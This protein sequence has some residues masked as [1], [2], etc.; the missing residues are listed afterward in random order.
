M[1]YRQKFNSAYE[2]CN[3]QIF[4]GAGDYDIP[5]IKPESVELTN[6]IGYNFAKSCKEPFN[7]GIHFFIDDYQFNRLWTN[8]DSYIGQLD[9]FKCVC[10]P[11]FSLY[12]D[13]PQAVQIYNHYRKCW[14]GAYWQQYGITV[15][16]TVTW[17]D[18]RS[19][20]WCFDGV[21]RNSDIAVSSVGTRIDNTA[22]RLF[23]IGYE[24]MLEVLKPEHIYFYGKI[25]D[26]IDTTNITPI[27]P[28][29]MQVRKRTGRG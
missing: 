10:T 4:E 27:E 8:P 25:P 9:K 2:N 23:N 29:Y 1:D 18:E 7:F 28:F 13:F 24:K 6:F 26:G 15:I 22:R 5:Q 11:D 16:P 14:L 3:K 21:P 17:S 20:E 19:F 12:C